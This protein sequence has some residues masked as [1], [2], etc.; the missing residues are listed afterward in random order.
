M[1]NNDTMD[2]IS[3]DDVIPNANATTSMTMNNDNSIVK[4]FHANDVVFYNKDVDIVD[5]FEK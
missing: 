2:N 5:F 3:H 4:F 1:I